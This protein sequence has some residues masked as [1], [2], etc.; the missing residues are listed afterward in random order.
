[1]IG[2]NAQVAQIMGGG[3]AQVNAHYA[4]TPF[5]GI[6]AR[7]GDAVNVR[8]EQGCTNYRLLPLLMSHGSSMQ[9][10][11]QHGL[12]IEY[13]NSSGVS[14]SPVW[15]TLRKS[16]ELA[17]FGEVPSGVNA[18]RCS[19]RCAGRFTRASPGRYTFGLVSAGLTDCLSTGKR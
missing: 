3:S 16:S 2:P 10:G 15:S 14:G 17:S 12:T 6:V 4:V 19:V 13:F 5:A 1:M 18:E 8:F 7:V 11:V 9:E